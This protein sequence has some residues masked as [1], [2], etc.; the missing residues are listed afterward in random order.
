MSYF[1][2]SG[3]G[4]PFP[5]REEVCVFCSAWMLEM[6]RKSLGPLSVVVLADGLDFRKTDSPGSELLF[7]RHSDSIES[8]IGARHGRG[9]PIMAVAGERLTWPHVTGADREGFWTFQDVA[10]LFVRLSLSHIF[11]CA[12]PYSFR[13]S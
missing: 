7:G 2:K 12:Y 8:S 6:G 11:P 1:F 13:T 10:V 9:F 5:D 4:S 3:C